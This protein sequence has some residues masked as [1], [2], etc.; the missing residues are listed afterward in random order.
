M[1]AIVLGAVIVAAFILEAIAQRARWRAL[2]SVA[3]EIVEKTDRTVWRLDQFMR[4]W[5]E[6]SG[7]V[8]P[9]DWGP[10]V[11]VASGGAHDLPGPPVDSAAWSFDLE[12][13]CAARAKAGE[14][15]EAIAAF[16][17]A[18]TERGPAAAVPTAGGVDPLAPAPKEPGAPQG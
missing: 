17:R 3:L 2:R 9:S 18:V 5:E 12:A 7:Y 14:P 6:V 13:A 15:P 10:P 11:L 8:C 4:F 1:L 16:R